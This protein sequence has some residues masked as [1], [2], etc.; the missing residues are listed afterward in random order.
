MD[1]CHDEAS[2]FEAS[3]SLDGLGLF[4]AR[5]HMGGKTKFSSGG[6]HLVVILSFVQTHSLW[7]G[8]GGLGTLDDDAFDG[9]GH[10]FP[11]MAVRPLDHRANRHAMSLRQH[12]AFDAPLPRSVGLGPVF[13]PPN[14]AL[15][16]APSIESQSH[17]IP[18]LSSNC[19]TPACQNLRKT[20]AS[21]HA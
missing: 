4:P 19:S 5:T 6:V 9:R 11:S 20:P 10:P 15:V 8:L 2:R 12:A 1:S 16:I 18:Q 21:T 7:M 17:S 3:F 13:S 14:G